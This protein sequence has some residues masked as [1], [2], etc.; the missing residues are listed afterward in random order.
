MSTGLK[1][2]CSAA[3]GA[4]CWHFVQFGCTVFQQHP[5]HCWLPLLAGSWSIG[6]DAGRAAHLS[7][8]LLNFCPEK[9]GIRLGR[10]SPLLYCHFPISGP[11]EREEIPKKSYLVLYWSSLASKR[12]QTPSWR[13]P[14]GGGNQLG[15]VCFIQESMG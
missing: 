12:D 15:A 7:C 13:R 1:S 3:Q 2:G 5:Q 10:P 11:N 6:M 4:F 14:P 9:A 8:F